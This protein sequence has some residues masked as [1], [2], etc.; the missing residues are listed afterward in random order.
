[1]NYNNRWTKGEVKDTKEFILGTTEEEIKAY[2]YT[3]VEAFLDTYQ[4]Q[5]DMFCNYIDK[6]LL[7]MRPSQW[8]L[9]VFMF[10]TVMKHGV[11]SQA[12]DLFGNSKCNSPGPTTQ[13]QRWCNLTV[14]SVI[15]SSAVTSSEFQLYE[16]KQ[17]S[18]NRVATATFNYCMTQQLLCVS[19]MGCSSR[20]N[21]SC[22]SRVNLSNGINYSTYYIT[23]ILITQSA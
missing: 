22:L 18:G 17:A 21:T 14:I 11:I 2:T 16:G 1:M 20:G 10:C 13:A 3:S 15:R 23:F 7:Y 8:L 4:L 12:S 6:K 19:L 5:F 9:T